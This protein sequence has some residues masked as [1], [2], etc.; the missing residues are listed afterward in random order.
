MKTLQ[1]VI[2][3]QVKPKKSKRPKRLKSEPRCKICNSDLR[4]EVDKRIAEGWSFEKIAKWLK[5]KGLTVS[6]KSVERHARNHFPIREEIREEGEKAAQSVLSQTLKQA[7][8]LVRASAYGASIFFEILEKVQPKVLEELLQ[9]KLDPALYQV[10]VEGARRMLELAIKAK[11]SEI[12]IKILDAAEEEPKEKEPIGF[13]PEVMT[14]K[15]LEEEIEQL[16]QELAVIE[17]KTTGS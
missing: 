13:R 1:I 3:R 11:D 15:E 5:D 4:P 14:D 10:V 9:E 16:E 2:K 8:D 17:E 7:L 12:N 6:K